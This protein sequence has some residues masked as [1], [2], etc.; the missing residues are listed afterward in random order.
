MKKL[1]LS[2]SKSTQFAMISHHY[3]WLVTTHFE[4]QN[5]METLKTKK[6]F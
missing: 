5:F 3:E 4:H 2:R 6:L 1:E